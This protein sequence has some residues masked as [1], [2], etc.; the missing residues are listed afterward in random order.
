MRPI[1]AVDGCDRY[2][3]GGAYCQP[4][5]HRWKRH[6]DPLAGARTR[7]TGDDERRFW[8]LVDKDGPLPVDRPDLGPCWL[9]LG[10]H[11]VKGYARISVNNRYRVAHRWAYERF[12]APVP[13]G[14]Q[15]DHLCR[16]RGCVNP[17]HLEPVTPRENVLRGVGFCA[18]NAAKTHCSQGHEFDEENTRLLPG[19]G[20]ACRACHR[21]TVYAAKRAKRA[22][23]RAA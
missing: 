7:I 16:N 1:C 12:V 17:S 3:H 14:L 8:S 11:L 4:H 19:G 20:R 18:V 21:A 10:G 13:D 22:Q 2:V 9:W 6:G 5:Y 15:L 23:R